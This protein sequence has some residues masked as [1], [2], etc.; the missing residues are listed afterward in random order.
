[1]IWYILGGAA[2]LALGIY[3]GLG[4]PG[5]PGREDRVLPTRSERSR[6]QRHFTPLDLL[7]RKE[8]DRDR[9]FLTNRPEHLKRR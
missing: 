7:R 8:R 2:A 1:M 5:L 9:R 6:T 4:F 3:V